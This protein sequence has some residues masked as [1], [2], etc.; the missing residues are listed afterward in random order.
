MA[1]AFYGKNYPTNPVYNFIAEFACSISSK[2]IDHLKGL[3]ESE[4]SYTLAYWYFTDGSLDSLN[5]DNLLYCLIKQLCAKTRTI[6]D[7]V[8]NLWNER[9]GAKTPA[10][11]RRPE[12]IL[13]SVVTE[14]HETGHRVLIVLD[15]LDEYPVTARA[16]SSGARTVLGREV[17]LQWLQNFHQH[18]NVH[19]LV[20]SR[21][22]DDIRVSFEHAMK[23]DVAQGVT[24]DLDSFIKTSINNIVQKKPWKLDYK[25]QISDRFRDNSERQVYLCF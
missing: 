7:S 18:P 22:E 11:G 14:L 19:A 5:V 17:V 1:R 4:P 23:L 12:D 9:A 24:S 6:P 25:N 2:I 16:G 13:D 8:R 20:T 21:D 15:G 10:S 3:S